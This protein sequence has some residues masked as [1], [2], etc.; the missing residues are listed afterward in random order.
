MPVLPNAT[1][2][3]LASYRRTRDGEQVPNTITGDVYEYACWNW[4]LS[5]ATLKNTDLTSTKSII[6]NIMQLDN[7][8]FPTAI[9]PGASQVYQGNDAEFVMMGQK[10]RDATMGGPDFEQSDVAQKDFLG[11]L[12]RIMLRANG[13]QPI[14]F[15]AQNQ[16]NVIVRSSNWWNTDHW[17]LKLYAGPNATHYVQTV[18][19]TPLM[20]SC[21]EVWDE[22]LA[23]VEISISGLHQ[24]QVDLLSTVPVCRCRA[25][26]TKKDRDQR[27][28]S[29]VCEAILAAGAGQCSAC[30]FV[31][32][33]THLGSFDQA[34]VFRWGVKDADKF[35]CQ[36][37]RSNVTILG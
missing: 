4:V 34:G 19:E 9:K 31:A 28:V 23:F 7:F 25:W 26:V 5:G 11:C 12:V 32:C 2:K 21:S 1:L 36:R 13:L 20:F 6:E 18:P 22:H 29:Y 27:D 3:K 8:G 30:G 16:Y 14:N 24:N 35:K 10:L 15:D 37:C 33:Q 17:A